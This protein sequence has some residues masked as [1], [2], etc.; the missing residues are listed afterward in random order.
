MPRMAVIDTT[1]YGSDTIPSLDEDGFIQYEGS[2]GRGRGRSAN[3]YSERR[4]GGSNAARGR[5][6][7]ND[8]GGRL[9]LYFYCTEVSFLYIMKI[10]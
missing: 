5:N 9:V 8:K 7:Y 6:S 3:R 10:L 1:E 2:G 4:P